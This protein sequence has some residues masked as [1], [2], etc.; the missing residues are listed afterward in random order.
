M[1]LS[2]RAYHTDA[3][4]RRNDTQNASSC[5]LER[6]CKSLGNNPNLR[7][8]SYHIDYPQTRRSLDI[9]PSNGAIDQAQYDELLSKEALEEADVVNIGF[10]N[11]S[12]LNVKSADGAYEVEIGG[13]LHLDYID[14]S[15][16]SRIAKIRLAVARF[17]G[18][19]SKQM[20]CS[21]I[22]GATPPN[23]TMRKTRS[24]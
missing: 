24:R 22:T 4:K 21:T 2:A 16:D 14:H 13:R 19:A 6:L 9:L 17:D 5:R 23:S 1:L 20:A 18:D 10:A 7:D 11:G 15:F 3:E 8:C 12:G